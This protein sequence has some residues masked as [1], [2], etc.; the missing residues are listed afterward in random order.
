MFTAD[1]DE[2]PI[3]R[4]LGFVS[5]ARSPQLKRLG[6]V[7]SA[8]SPQLKSAGIAVEKAGQALITYQINYR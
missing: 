7:S 8:R 6:F 3:I 1:M 2:R 4:S 5:S